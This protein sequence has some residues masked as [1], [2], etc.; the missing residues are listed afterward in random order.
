MITTKELRIGNYL[1]WDG[2]IVEVISI[3]GDTM[4]EVHSDI[5][6]FLSVSV[7]DDTEISG[8]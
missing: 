7:V 8:I 3:T 2:N 1:K 4:F 5:L 6:Q